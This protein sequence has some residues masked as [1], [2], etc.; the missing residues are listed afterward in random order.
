MNVEITTGWLMPLFQTDGKRIGQQRCLP[1]SSEN[2]K[3]FCM[4]SGYSLDS[5]FKFLWSLP[6]VD[7][8]CV[9]EMFQPLQ[10]CTGRNLA[11]KRSFISRAA[12]C[13][14]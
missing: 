12:L 10:D 3:S 2:E 11:K 1:L 6:T 4:L 8:N 9:A 5:G 7:C 13:G 14:R